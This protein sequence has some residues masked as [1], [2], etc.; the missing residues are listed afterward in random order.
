PTTWAA[1]SAAAPELVIVAPCG[2][3][4]DG[5]I[6][7]AQAAAQ[8]LPGV[9]VWAIDADG[10]VVRPG[11]RLVDGVEAIAAILHPDAVPAPQPPA[12]HRVTA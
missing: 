1:V 3:H 11:P 9:P 10:I 2:Y 8:A 7:Q 6:E 4:L 5:A 12:M